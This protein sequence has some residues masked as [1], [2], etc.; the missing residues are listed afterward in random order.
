MLAVSVIT[1][2]HDYEDSGVLINRPKTNPPALAA[3]AAA[4]ISISSIRNPYSITVVSVTS[5]PSSD[6]RSTISPTSVCAAT[7]ADSFFTQN[8]TFAE[9]G[10]M[11]FLVSPAAPAE[12]S[13]VVAAIPLNVANSAGAAGDTKI[14]IIPPSANVKF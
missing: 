1:M 9:G 4:V 7:V 12:L 10:M 8:F 6:S 2:H 11:G 13:T 3:T 5:I 14:P